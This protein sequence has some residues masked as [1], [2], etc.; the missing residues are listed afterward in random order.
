MIVS[1]YVVRT[2]RSR[3][4]AVVRMARMES[5]EEGE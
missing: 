5:V 2:P 4:V 3:S 1:W